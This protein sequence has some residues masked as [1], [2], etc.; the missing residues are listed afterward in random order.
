MRNHKLIISG[1]STLSIESHIQR[2]AL[3]SNSIANVIDSF[4]NVIPAL[5]EKLKTAYS[6][7]IAENKEI[8]K[9]LVE[10]HK[11]FKKLE[12][13]LPHA[14]YLNVAK[15][16][17]SVPEGFSGNFLEY[18]LF[19]NTVSTELFKEANQVLGDYN[20]VL[21]VF[22]SNKQDK[23]SLKDHT[24]LFNR[25]KE[26]RE[27]ITAG[28]GKYFPTTTTTSK[29][30]L[31]DVVG[32]FAELNQ[33]MDIADLLDKER[34]GQNI[35]QITTS[36]NRSVQLLEIVIKD[37]QNNGATNV[38]GNAAMNISKGA[39]ELGKFVELLGLYRYQV[40]AALAATN[41][42]MET[43]ERIV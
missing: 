27:A 15:V 34:Q 11:H 31:S 20:L 32:R 40:D 42:L 16:V 14:I 30:R 1:E 25:I 22:I 39:Y 19:L 18:L 35:R 43:V 36:V 38:S 8:D 6:Q 37:V 9:E 2:L 13:K 29:K 4:K 10:A 24:N 41:K 3:E 28:I 23:L 7:L 17:V 26:R 21:S 33:I 12:A 5:G